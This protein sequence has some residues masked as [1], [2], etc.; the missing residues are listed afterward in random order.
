M[1]TAKRTLVSAVFFA[2]A[3]AFCYTLSA[4]TLDGG[5]D[6]PQ[7]AVKVLRV[8]SVDMFFMPTNET[9]NVLKRVVSAGAD[10]QFLVQ[11]TAPS[12][13]VMMEG[14]YNDLQ[15]RVPNGPFTYYHANGRVSARGCYAMGVKTGVWQ[16]F[17]ARGSALA[18]RVYNGLNWEQT[19]FHLE[20]ATMRH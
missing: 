4:N 9:V 12:G 8:E 7:G 14:V 5:P 17:D 15:C 16:R 20:E 19:R 2:V 10:G 1:N 13:A 18:E 3:I 6:G 11:V